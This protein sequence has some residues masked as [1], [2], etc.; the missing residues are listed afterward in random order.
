MG[1]NPWL[2]SRS[3][4]EVTRPRPSSIK[5]KPNDLVARPRP[6]TQ[7]FKVNGKKMKTKANNDHD[8]D[9]E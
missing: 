8:D 6:R 7:Y 2:R 9:D 5:A 3:M 4:T 1:L